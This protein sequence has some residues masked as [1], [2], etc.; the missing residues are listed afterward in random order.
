M[1]PIVIICSDVTVDR[2]IR[3]NRFQVC[4]QREFSVPN[5]LPN[6]R[7]SANDPSYARNS[8]NDEL[9]LSSAPLL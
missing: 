5:D 9:K 4:F 8:T 3:H 6:T 7:N 2:K 1:I